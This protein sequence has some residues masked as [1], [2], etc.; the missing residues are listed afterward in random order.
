MCGTQN[1]FSG[2]LASDVGWQARRY[3]SIRV[4]IL[5]FL[6]RA[7]CHR[8]PS[9]LVKNK[10]IAFLGVDLGF[11]T[12]LALIADLFL[13]HSAS[14]NQ[15]SRQSCQGLSL[16]NSY[17]NYF[18]CFSPPTIP[19]LIEVQFHVPDLNYSSILYQQF[20]TSD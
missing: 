14:G 7:P 4:C 16:R 15:V 10:H 13:S 3:S 19:H 12:C 17:W 2:T 1:P 5:E 18:S 6:Q 11:T 20:F 8:R 9:L